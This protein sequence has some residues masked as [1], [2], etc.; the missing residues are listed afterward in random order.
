MSSHARTLDRLH[1]PSLEQFHRDY[2]APQKPCIITGVASQWPAVAKWSPEHFKE[3]L[4][5]LKI[6]YETWE[7]DES[8][9]NDPLDFVDKQKYH[10]ATMAEYVELLRN[11]KGRRIYS[12][13]FAILDAAPELA[14]E[15]GS[16]EPWMNIPRIYPERIRRQLQIKP[17][18][19]T[20]PEGTISVLHFDRAHNLFVQ[21]YGRKK[22]IVLPPQESDYVYWP[23]DDIQIDLM[24]FSPVD[25]ERPDLKRFPLFAK[26]Q[27]IEFELGPGDMLFLPVGWW[28]FVRS[29]EASISI[30]YF[31]LDLPGNALALRRYLFHYARRDLK[32]RLGLER[33]PQAAGS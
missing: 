32:R 31:W 23:C 29:L 4:P 21:L 9:T 6:R 25:V 24:H 12:A 3:R 26:A 22:W 28:H 19:W 10:E 11:S 17:F 14:R 7:G 27:P 33:K 20:G 8:V 30:N 5:E 13:Q 2:L 16:L 15:L 1:Q 18:L